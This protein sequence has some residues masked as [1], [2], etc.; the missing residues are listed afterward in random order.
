MINVVGDEITNLYTRHI[1]AELFPEACFSESFHINCSTSVTQTEKQAIAKVTINGESFAQT[2]NFFD[3]IT[4]RLAITTAVGKAVISYGMN[5]GRSTPPYGVLTNVR[6]FKIASDLISRYDYDLVAEKL[7]E[8]Y[9]VSKGKIEL[10]LSSAMFDY[11][12]KSQHKKNDVSVY[13]SIPF[14]PTR[15]NYC[16]FVS[17]AAPSKLGLLKSYVDDVIKEAVLVSKFIEKHSLRVKSI[18]IGGGTPTILSAEELD[19]LLICV[20]S[21]FS[22]ENLVEITLEAG[23]PDTITYDKLEIM[24]KHAVTR[25][26]VN[27]QST[28]DEVLKT[29]GRGHS[30]D[31]F[32]RAFE[33]VQ[34]FSFNTVN[35]DVIAG[36][37]GDTSSSFKSTINDVISLSPENITVHTLCMKKSSHLKSEQKAIYEMNIDKWIFY[38]KEQCILNGFYPYYLYRQKYSVGNHENVGYSIRGH[39]CYYNIAMMNEIENVIGIGAGAT[40]K[41]VGYTPTGKIEHFANY[42][43]P[44]EYIGNEQKIIDNLTEMD[45]LISRS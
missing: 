5:K 37:D 44:T 39:E 1:I 14:C 10:L 38:S 9:W 13:I 18:Y 11:N 4:P 21:V 2:E 26:C 41:L 36:L 22:K 23:R 33:L 42:K 32:F 15:C 24:K 40:S 30:A 16:S 19:R 27:C 8:N 12:F 7:F 43:Y 25:T 29:I 6:P 17:T 45:K 28:N 20:N 34:S 3:H 35:I 31:D